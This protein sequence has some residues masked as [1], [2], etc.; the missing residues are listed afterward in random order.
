MAQADTIEINVI[1]P[2]TPDPL[3]TKTMN[4]EKELSRAE[5]TNANDY[6][7]EPVL[8]F[9]RA[10]A[11]VPGDHP[12][13][14]TSLRRPSIV[15]MVNSGG[16]VINQRGSC[17]I[18]LE[19]LP[20]QDVEM[21]YH[22]HGHGARRGSYD[23]SKD[24]HWNQSLDAKGSTQS[25][26]EDSVDVKCKQSW[27]VP[28][29][30]SPTLEKHLGKTVVEFLR[31]RFRVALL[32]ISLFTLI[33]IVFFAV[34]I[35]FSASLPSDSFQAIALNTDLAIYSVKYEIWYVIGAAVLF[36]C[37]TAL[38]IVTYAKYYRIVAVPLSI[39][40]IVVL[41][42]CSYALALALHFD[43]SVQGFLTM[44]YVAQFT[45]TSVV[46]LMTFMLSRMKT[47]VS[48]IFCVVYLILLEAVLAAVTF[49]PHAVG[50]DINKRA[51]PTETYIYS[52]VA[53][54]MFYICLN[55]VGVSS[56]HL[57]QI[58]QRTTFWKIAQCVLTQKALELERELEEKT[59]LSMMPKPFA[60]DLMDVQVQMTFMLKTK[61]GIESDASLDPL[62]QTVS[63]PFNL[64]SMNNVSILFADIVDFT[65]FSSSL[66]ASE[67][68]GILNDVF[69]VF[70]EL[71]IETNCEKISTLGD[72][73]FCVSGCPKS[74]EDHADNCVRM[75]LFIVDALEDFR[76]KTGLPIQM[77]IGIHTGSVFCGVMGTKRFKF[78]VWSK[79]VRIATQVE[80]VGL[81]GRVLV[82]SSTKTFLSD[83]YRF[84]HV[85]VPS[86]QSDLS[87][88]KLY[89]VNRPID[90]VTGTESVSPVV[91]VE[92][93]F[94]IFHSVPSQQNC[95]IIE[96][97]TQKSPTRLCP[98]W[99]RRQTTTPVGRPLR[100]S[101]TATSIVDIFSRQKQLQR[102]TSYAELPVPEPTNENNDK[103]VELM[104]EQKV[105]FD[106]YF[107]PQLHAV[108]LHFHDSDLEATYRNNGQ[109]LDDGSNGGMSEITLGF[110]ITKLSYMID[111]TILFINY[112]L[113]MIG[114]VVCLSSDDTLSE[115]WPALL[116]VLLFGMIIYVTILVFVTAVFVPKIFPTK[117]AV[118]SMFI[119]NWYA[120]AIVA[121][122]MIYYP[123]TIVCVSIAQ[124]KTGFDSV[125]E[126]AHVQM[127]FFITILVLISSINFMDVS[128]LVKFVGGL[129][130]GVLAISM[131]VGVHM[132]LCIEEIGTNYTAI[133][134]VNEN[135]RVIPT[136]SPQS[137]VMTYYT[138]HVAPEAIVLMLLVLILL[139]VVN[140]MSEVSVR[141][142][143]I[144]RIE[145]SARRRLARIRKAQADWLLFNIIPNHVARQLRKTGKYS[146]NHECVGVIFASI[147]N[148]RD[149][150]LNTP[151]S[152]EESLRVLNI[153]ISEF[154]ALLDRDQ[155][156]NVEKIKTIGST[157]MAASGLSLG[158]NEYSGVQHLLELVDFAEQLVEVLEQVN[159]KMP[160]FVFR[161]RIG[162][163]YGPVTSGVVGSS[164]MLYDIWG[165]TV[166]VASRMD[167][168]GVVNKIHM[169]ENCL[170]KLLT[171]V[172]FETSKLVNVKG[173]G[174]MR[175]VFV[176][177]GPS[178][179]DMI[180][181]RAM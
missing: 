145:A 53:R 8:N 49:A 47:W 12:A 42:C 148:F 177:R 159:S 101:Q 95:S 88:L 36:V 136:E 83:Y 137:Y 3:A 76:R 161:M 127:A 138:R 97:P 121:L 114:C 156:L 94:E 109:D 80:S 26:G 98:F 61:V 150:Q 59:I 55:L 164:K 19:Q 115:V 20:A 69:S 104:E 173:K 85:S 29:F 50:T 123:M 125:S 91:N 62:F 133:N 147:V 155:F 17:E 180:P 168:T 131:I 105:N 68:V 16:L 139:T 111:T 120:R 129:L 84:E 24:P 99:R 28:K 64:C 66:S 100:E 92:E 179:N 44:S 23:A 174:E 124:C 158:P 89:F 74:E 32:F 13:P 117:F 151:N 4:N 14:L 58:R 128:H 119:I 9:T 2:T 140:R 146:Q 163:N 41:M 154:D 181:H 169:P 110:R 45:I 72:C 108:S 63:A 134:P 122:F 57:T 25:L 149:F 103:I 167:S 56:A 82:S 11:S 142:S 165:D 5:E 67:L 102:C 170:D 71:V 178:R 160:G 1:S 132:T 27:W 65:Q 130:S 144:A 30:N 106:T 6:S 70:D 93:D 33:W 113:I 60:D 37:V 75:G 135:G 162:F 81:P 116:G 22:Y 79:D 90:P 112:L 86:G 18:N 21:M 38:L 43:S 87:G 54:V 10:R 15:E 107:D 77:R 166:N 171:F 39:V 157:Y 126:L 172:S 175:T 96:S 143:F 31:R 46:I 118:F 40:L 153:I 141:L 176:K 35:P 78:D 51:F 152:D 52:C 34:S 73:Y 48:L 7:A